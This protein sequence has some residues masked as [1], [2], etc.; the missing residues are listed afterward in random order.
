MAYPRS[1]YGD[2]MEQAMRAEERSCGNPR[3]GCKHLETMLGR[4][5]CM[6]GRR[7]VKKCRKFELKPLTE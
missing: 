7:E 3:P 6:K 4:E 1:Y 5:V 2:P